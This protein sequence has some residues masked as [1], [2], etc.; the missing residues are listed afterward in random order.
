MKDIM[1]YPYTVGCHYNAGQYNIFHSPLHWPMQNINQTLD[2][3]KTLYLALTGELW[4]VYC[5]DFGEK[6]S[7]YNGTALY[8]VLT[9]IQ[10]V[11][12]TWCS[13]Y[14]D[15][16][17]HVCWGIRAGIR[18]SKYYLG[19][20]QTDQRSPILTRYMLNFVGG[21]WIYWMRCSY[22]TIFFFPKFSH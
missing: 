9:R 3:Q 12:Y 16:S 14:S 4:S 11:N 7:R 19:N 13:W 1:C 5:E 17:V 2:S 22:N 10:W 6:L 20:H 21:T 8:D 15:I 18:V